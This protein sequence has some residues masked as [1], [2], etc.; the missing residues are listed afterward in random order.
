[1]L[2]NGTRL[3]KILSAVRT[4]CKILS[5]MSTGW[6]LL[7]NEVKLSVRTRRNLNVSPDC[8]VISDLGYYFYRSPQLY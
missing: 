1:M 6:N 3:G 8:T 2:P 4:E 7:D 5:P